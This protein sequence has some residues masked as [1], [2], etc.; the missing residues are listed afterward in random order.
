ML[1][2]ADAAQPV[3]LVTTAAHLHR[4]NR[5]R[6]C[7][8]CNRL[9]RLADCGAEHDIEIALQRVCLART[10]LAWFGTRTVPIELVAIIAVFGWVYDRRR[11]VA[12]RSDE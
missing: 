9:A 5:L 1:E 12:A 11:Q 2:I 8:G 10:E 7:G 6:A 4:R 3:D